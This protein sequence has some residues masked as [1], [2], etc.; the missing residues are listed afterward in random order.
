[1]KNFIINFWSGLKAAI[2]DV[3]TFLKAVYSDDG[4]PSSS[5]I[6]TFI[7]AM[8]SSGILWRVFTHIIA[9]TDIGII[10]AWL[11]NLPIII[12]ALV[13]FF[14]APYGVN[15]GSGAITDLVNIIKGKQ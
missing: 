3:Y 7:L 12:S 5:R 13:L 11:G 2:I 8:V 15:K 6:L 9:I 14:T 10:S 1:M 4:V